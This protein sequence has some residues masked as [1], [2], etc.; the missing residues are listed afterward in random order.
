MLKHW[1]PQDGND[2]QISI[3][4]EDDSESSEDS[5]DETLDGPDVGPIGHELDF[6]ERDFDVMGPEIIY[7]FPEGFIDVRSSGRGISLMHHWAPHDGDTEVEAELV[8][9]GVAEDD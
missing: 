8:A 6:H 1:T 5:E 4:E 9:E 3:D 2:D 7:H